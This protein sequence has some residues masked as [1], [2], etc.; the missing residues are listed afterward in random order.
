MF[1]TIWIFVKMLFLWVALPALGIFLLLKLFF[2]LF[3]KLG[4]RFYDKRASKKKARQMDAILAKART[5]EEKKTVRY[6]LNH[7]EDEYSD[8]DYRT[9]MKSL[10]KEGMETLEFPEENGKRISMFF[11]ESF[12]LT[13]PEEGALLRK[14]P[15]G[16]TIPSRKQRL[17]IFLGSDKLYIRTYTLDMMKKTSESETTGYAYADI[18]DMSCQRLHPLQNINGN[19]TR[20]LASTISILSKGGKRKTWKGIGYD[21]E[22]LLI[23]LKEE[24]ELRKSR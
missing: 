7:D 3:N 10:W 4:N 19:E 1:E 9:E 11:D 6:F 15:D 13:D 16:K 18:V 2:L 5:E 23:E 12:N 21:T 14:C 20:V 17:S 8:H 24:V 22:P